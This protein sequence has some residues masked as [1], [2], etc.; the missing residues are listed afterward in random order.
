MVIFSQRHQKKIINYKSFRNHKL[1]LHVR[2]T[3]ENMEFSYHF[4]GH[5]VFG[6][7]EGEGHQI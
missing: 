1:C 7:F 3:L 4:G 5:F 2:H 6:Y